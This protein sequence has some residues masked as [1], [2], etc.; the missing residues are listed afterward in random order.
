[1]SSDSTGLIVKSPFGTGV[2]ALTVINSTF[3]QNVYGVSVN[4]TYAPLFGNNTITNNTT[5]LLLNGASPATSFGDNR[6][7]GNNTDG[8][9]TTTLTTK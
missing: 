7:A 1:F 6:L 2:S 9:F 3:Q 4:T 5:G 8:A